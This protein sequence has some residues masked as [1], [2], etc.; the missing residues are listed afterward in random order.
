MVTWLLKYLTKKAQW[1][2]IRCSGRAWASYNSCLLYEHTSMY[3]HST[4]QLSSEDEGTAAHHPHCL[5]THTASPPTLPHHRHTFTSP[6]AHIYMV[7]MHYLTLQHHQHTF[8][9]SPLT[10]PYTKQSSHTH[11]SHTHH[12]HTHHVHTLTTHTLTTHNYKV[13]SMDPNILT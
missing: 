9:L 12:S 8:T 1:N 7:T 2:R 6:Q 13:Y 5:T 3:V 4:L 10:L 11:Q